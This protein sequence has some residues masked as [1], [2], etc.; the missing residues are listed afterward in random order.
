LHG[1]SRRRLAQPLEEAYG[2]HR[3]DQAKKER[4]QIETTAAALQAAQTSNETDSRFGKLVLLLLSFGLDGKGPLHSAKD[5]AEDA[6]TKSKTREAA[7]GRVARGQSL[8][9]RLVDSP[10]GSAVL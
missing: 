4:K 1:Q 10:P 8:E 3:L 2:S 9:A 7:I 5:V 6:L